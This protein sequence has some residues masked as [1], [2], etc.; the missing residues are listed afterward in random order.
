MKCCLIVFAKEPETGRV[1]TRLKKHLNAKSRSDLYKAFL[2]DTLDIARKVYCKEKVI[3]YQAKQKPLYLKRTGK[4]FAFYKQNGKDL[5][6]RM[7]N[8]FTYAKC[9]S[10]N[11][12]VIIGSDSPN[13]P[14]KF[15]KIA[16]CRLN[17]YDIVIGPSSDGGYYLIGLKEPEA[18]LFKGVK[19]STSDVLD[20]T[21]KQAK[22]L[23]RSVSLLDEWHDV[24]DLQGLAVLKNYLVKEKN[25]DIAKY[26]RKALK[27]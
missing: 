22:N 15:I 3:F 21:L 23:G 27:I 7:H 4:D 12:I 16:F 8:A 24:D 18:A 2:K 14:V 19:W 11:K 9:R 13:L 26:T 20:N 17:E 6:E 25:Q 1:K 10:A 5:G